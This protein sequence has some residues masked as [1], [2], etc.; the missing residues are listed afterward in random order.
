MR[1]SQLLGMA[2][3]L[4]LNTIVV[5]P[6]LGL[7]MLINHQQTPTAST[8]VVMPAW[9]PFSPGF[10]PIYVGLLFVTWWL[11]VA[12]SDQRRFRACLTANICA[13]FLVMPW[14]VLLPTTK[15]RPPLPQGTWAE[16]FRWLWTVDQPFN[17]TPC[18]HGIGPV[19]AVWF[20][21]KEYPQW[22]VPLVAAL[23]LALPSIALV[24]QHRPLDIVLGTVAAA[25]GIILAEYLQR[26]FRTVR[27]TVAMT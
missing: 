25:I 22:R 24:W 14:W 4:A 18:A 7:Y 9:V 6:M 26:R 3:R 10:L 1:I 2:K 17:I 21:V 5:W 23:L 13:W 20:V 12:L 19:I 16:G 27:A 8:V 15:L 11:P